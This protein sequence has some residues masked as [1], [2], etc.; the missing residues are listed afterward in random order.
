MTTSILIYFDNNDYR[1]GSKQLFSADP[2]YLPRPSGGK[3]NR[4]R[5][6]SGIIALGS[7]QQSM[8]S[9]QERSRDLQCFCQH[10][11]LEIEIT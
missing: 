8:F 3:S 2:S 4:R 5:E 9:K 11:Q 10:D 7:R 6:L 1:E